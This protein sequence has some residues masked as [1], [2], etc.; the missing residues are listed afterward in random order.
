M[1]GTVLL[2]SSPLLL[3]RPLILTFFSAGKFQMVVIPGVGHVLHEVRSS[4]LSPSRVVLL[5]FVGVDTQ[6][7]EECRGVFADFAKDSGLDASRRGEEGRGYLRANKGRGGRAVCAM[8]Y[9]IG[10]RSWAPIRSD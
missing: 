6:S 3:L 4:P 2:P 5:L 8:M 9:E 10:R 7:E 1:P